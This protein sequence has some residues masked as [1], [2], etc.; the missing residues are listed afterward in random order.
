MRREVV[1]NALKWLKEYNVLY[2]EIDIVEDNLNWIEDRVEQSLPCIDIIEEST[3]QETAASIDLGPSI[4][5]VSD[6]LETEEYHED[7]CGTAMQ[8]NDECR[9]SKESGEVCETIE[10]ALK[11]SVNKAVMPWPYVSPDPVSEYDEDANL[12]PKA[13]PWL[14][15]GGTGDFFQYREEALTASNWIKRMVLYVDGRFAKDKMWGF[16][17]LNFASRRKNQNDG[18]FFV[19]F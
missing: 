4:S 12:F 18:A 6:V 19:N 14:F 16:F 17:A 3:E 8:S 13:F 9:F 2:K 11:L 7:V 1:L 10:D 5:Q 15:P